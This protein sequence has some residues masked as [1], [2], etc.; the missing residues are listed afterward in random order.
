MLSPQHI[1][2]LIKHWLAATLHALP[3]LT[4]EVQ[5]REGR[6]LS[7]CPPDPA[8]SQKPVFFWGGNHLQVHV[9]GPFLGLCL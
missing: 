8:P 2:S 6:L 4:P 5:R 9:V 1:S 7:T 3:L